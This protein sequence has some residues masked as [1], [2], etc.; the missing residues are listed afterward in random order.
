MANPLSFTASAI[1]VTTLTFHISKLVKNTFHA[2]D[3]ILALEDEVEDVR[4]LIK[5]LQPLRQKPWP[6]AQQTNIVE[7]KRVP[8]NVVTKRLLKIQGF[9][10]KLER[11]KIKAMQSIRYVAFR[12][13]IN[14]EREGLGDAKQQL[15]DIVCVL[16]VSTTRSLN[17]QA[18]NIVR[19]VEQVQNT[20][21]KD[22]QEIITRLDQC[23]GPVQNVYMQDY[24]S[25]LTRFDQYLSPIQGPDVQTH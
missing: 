22:Q 3:E 4:A 15:F 11:Y 6:Q 16:N 7:A 13:K 14:A 19:N 9:M 12:R 10:D 25:I 5:L 24:R 1:A 8:D 18:T 2:S 23:L 20:H 17:L 21:N